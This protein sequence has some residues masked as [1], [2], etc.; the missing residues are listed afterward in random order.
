M[1]LIDIYS[2]TALT[3]NTLSALNDNEGMTFYKI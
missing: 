2:Y 3:D 1:L